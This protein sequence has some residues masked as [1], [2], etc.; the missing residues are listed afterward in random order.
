MSQ[1]INTKQV[2]RLSLGLAI[3][4]ALSS[5]ILWKGSWLAS[6]IQSPYDEHGVGIFVGLL[7]CVTSF[8]WSFA[9][10]ASLRTFLERVFPPIMIV[11]LLASRLFIAPMGFVALDTIIGFVIPAVGTYLFVFAWFSV[12]AAHNVEDSLLSIL[13][14]W[15]FTV[16]LRA[17]FGLF[18]AEI[19]KFALSMLLICAAWLLLIGQSKR[20]EVGLPMV[21]NVPRENKNSYIH[22]L[23]SIWKCA[24]Y[25]GAFAFLGGVTRSLSLQIVAMNYINYASILGG[26]LSALAIVAIWRVKTVRYSISHVFQVLFPLLVLLVCAL[27]F[28]DMKAFF[29]PAAALYMVY[30]FMSLSMQVLCV[31]VTH[32]YGVSPSFCISFQ[33]GVSV[34]MQGLGYLLGNAVNSEPFSQIPPLATIA[35]ISLAM[36]ALVVYFTRGLFISQETDGRSVEFLSL[37]RKPH[38][39]EAPFDETEIVAD[40]ETADVAADEGP[41]AGDE[42]PAA[43]HESDLSYVG[44]LSARCEAIGEEYYLSQREIEVMQLF[45]QGYTMSSIAK[46][47][48]ISENTVKTHTRRLYSKLGINKKQQLFNLVNGRTE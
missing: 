9:S 6:P 35:L 42:E 45:M 46:E 41:A 12:I 32:D 23:G 17:F 36:L 40:D 27:P 10:P 21:V 25:C 33:T 48:F 22:A 2:V 44:N 18:E 24:L 20:I 8:V 16:A 34:C 47:L 11:A 15:P 26:L 13:L 7:T 30:S 38:Q 31:Q 19:V 1:L 37:A 39:V 5:L 29:W 43:G 14:A 3:S 28:F 4:M